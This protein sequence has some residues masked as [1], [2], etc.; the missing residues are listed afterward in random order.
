[1]PQTQHGPSVA[2]LSPQEVTY[3]HFRGQYLIPN[4]PCIFP[5]QLAQHW[6]LFDKWFTNEQKLDWQYLKE[7]YGSLKVDC[8]DCRP[9]SDEQKEEET[10]ST[11][12]EL[13]DL[14]QA[15]KGQTRYL[16]DWHLPLEIQRTAEN[17]KKG[18][19][20]LQAELYQVEQVCLDDWMNELEGNEHEGRGDDF[21]FVYAGGENTFTP[22][23]RDVYCSYSIST[24]IHGSKLWYLFPPTCTAS[25]LPLITRA[26]HEGDGINCDE[27]S[28]E[29][30][31]QFEAKGM[32]KVWQEPKETIFIPSGWYHSVHNLSHPT[33]SLNHNWLNSHNLPSIYSSLCEEVARCRD[34]IS[35][36]K[37]LLIEKVKRQGTA[38]EGEE[39]WKREWEEEVDGLVERSEGWSWRTFWKMIANTLKSL[40]I[41]QE[42]LES[43]FDKSR[44][45][46]IP[47]EARPPTSYTL[48]QLRPLLDDFR[49]KEEREWKWLDGLNVVLNEV[50]DE[51]ARLSHALDCNGH[52]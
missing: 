16:K 25:L 4:T 24:Q 33:F 2:R 22:L 20:K 44:W 40:E 45:P 36:V 14:W 12:G 51:I 38:A 23:H 39:A 10:I 17:T 21:R 9:V 29:L 28:D 50:D 52:S 15:G 31:A 11:F 5:P 47:P 8:I 7:Q 27:W 43:R 1:M 46:L 3:S 42:D 41:S 35:D 48:Q 32:I 19:E 13:L 6:K 37:D 49:K 18:K 26:N 30:K 34:A